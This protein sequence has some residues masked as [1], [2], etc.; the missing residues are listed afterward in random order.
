MSYYQGETV[1]KEYDFRDKFNAL[2]DPDTTAVKIYDPQ[3]TKI[4]PDPT[5]N[6]IETGKYE[7]N[8]TFASDAVIGEYQVFVTATKGTNTRDHLLIV[9]VKKVPP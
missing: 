9:Q 4:T 2:I 5:L 6:K 1:S 8:Y 3:G 7:L